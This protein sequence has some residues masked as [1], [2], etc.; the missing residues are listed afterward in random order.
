MVR[1]T[2]LLDVVQL[3]LR[4]IANSEDCICVLLSGIR[5]SLC[6]EGRD[7]CD[8]FATSTFTLFCGCDNVVSFSLDLGECDTPF[9]G[10]VSLGVQ[11]FVFGQLAHAAQ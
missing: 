1:V 2:I 6:V 5:V 10:R 3:G 9:A 7:L 8:Q 4:E 11:L